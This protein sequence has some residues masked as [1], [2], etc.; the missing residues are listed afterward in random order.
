MVARRGKA[1]RFPL[2]YLVQQQP[3]IPRALVTNRP[4]CSPSLPT[5]VRSGGLADP[6]LAADIVLLQ[7]EPSGRSMRSI[8]PAHRLCR[9]MS[10]HVTDLIDKVEGHM[11]GLPQAPFDSATVVRIWDRQIMSCCW[12]RRS[13][14]SC[15]ASTP[16]RPTSGT[17]HT[18]L[19]GRLAVPAIDGVDGH[20]RRSLS[21]RSPVTSLS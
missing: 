10:P 3:A 12:R 8:G 9:A 17:R 20:P 18:R 13:S 14:L 7:D 16:P 1:P 15:K 4:D 6:C 11:S 2:A 21:G 5:P 19:I